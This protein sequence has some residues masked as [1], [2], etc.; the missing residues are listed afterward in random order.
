MERFILTHF[1]FVSF[2]SLY[3][4]RLFSLISTPF[5]S[6][7]YLALVCFR[8]CLRH[9]LRLSWLCLFMLCSH[10]TFLCFHYFFSIFPILPQ[11]A[12]LRVLLFVCTIIDFRFHLFSSIVTTVSVLSTFSIPIFCYF[13]YLEQNSVVM[14]LRVEDT[15]ESDE[16]SISK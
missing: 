5:P 11:R 7:S 13:C 14:R 3:L 2:S 6:H 1:S 15:V 16:R 4:P 12:S 8:P 9:R 10:I